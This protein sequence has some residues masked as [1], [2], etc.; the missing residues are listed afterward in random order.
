MEEVFADVLTRQM[1]MGRLYA[2]RLMTQTAAQ[3]DQ[4]AVALARG[5]RGA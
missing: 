2:G 5:R 3:T 4:V 1:A